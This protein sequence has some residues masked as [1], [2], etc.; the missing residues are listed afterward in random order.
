MTY[1]VM[2]GLGSNL[3]D[4][5]HQLQQAL[6]AF[7]AVPFIQRRKTSSFYY[8]PP[9]GPPDQPDYV[10]AV[11]LLQT[12]YLPLQLLDQLQQ[13][14]HQQ[15]RVRTVRWGPRT[16]DIDILFINQLVIRH[17]RLRVPHPGVKLR[18]FV[19]H[20]LFEI[21]PDFCFPDGTPLSK[22]IK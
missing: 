10:N 2:V 5:Q 14:E 8:S 3:N 13:I 16:L 20:P 17:P 18:D 15:G 7:D 21:A 9:M 4:P 1:H 11:V 6:Q 12:E 22:L 19:L